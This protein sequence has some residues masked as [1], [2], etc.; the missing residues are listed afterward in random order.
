MSKSSRPFVRFLNLYRTMNENDHYRQGKQ[1][2]PEAVAILAYVSSKEEIGQHTTI[3]H[4]V[5]KNVF[6]APPTVQRRIQ[7]LLDCKFIEFYA[8]T[9]KRH[10]LLKISTTGEKYLQDCSDLMQEAL[11]ISGKAL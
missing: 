10:R 3:S 1:M 7:E 6:G 9:D 5:K 8:G 11:V 2:H 4:V